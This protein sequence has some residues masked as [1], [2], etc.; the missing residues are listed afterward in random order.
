[1]LRYTKKQ[2]YSISN[3]TGLHHPVRKLIDIYHLASF[4]IEFTRERTELRAGYRRFL[5]RLIRRYSTTRSQPF[6][7]EKN[8]QA[9][10]AAAIYKR[11]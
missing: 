3:G 6:L 2:Y 4:Q 7:V 11:I 8:W 10:A 9:V 5:T 1:M